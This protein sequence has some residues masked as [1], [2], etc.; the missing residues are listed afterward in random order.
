MGRSNLSSRAIPPGMGIP[1]QA[2]IA[3]DH[4]KQNAGEVQWHASRQ[5]S[6]REDGS[7]DFRVRVDG[8]IGWWILGYSDRGEA[9]SPP[10]LRRQVARMASAVA[11]GYSQ[12]GA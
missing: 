8:R 4:G 1:G 12:E 11:A 10:A 3:Y 2:H 6:W 9:V 5:T 7:I